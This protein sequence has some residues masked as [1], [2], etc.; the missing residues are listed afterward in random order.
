MYFG[1]YTRLHVIYNANGLTS[2]ERR[3]RQPR[4]YL[5]TRDK[6]RCLPLYLFQGY[7]LS[8]YDLSPPTEC[9]KW[10]VIFALIR[11]T[12]EIVSPSI[13][14]PSM[15]HQVGND[16]DIVNFLTGY[17]FLSPCCKMAIRTV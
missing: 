16:N 2:M 15:T 9:G 8:N 10:C 5:C 13:A 4:G 14:L 11:V 7:P 17:A 12:S 6:R 1:V 3:A